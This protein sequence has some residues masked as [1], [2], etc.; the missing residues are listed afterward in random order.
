MDYKNEEKLVLRPYKSCDAKEIV[1]WCKDEVSFRKW[2]ADRWEKF[3]LTPDD[4]NDKY[5]KNNGDCE[6]EDNFYPLTFVA[7]GRIVGHMIIRY[8]DEKKETMRFGFVIVDDNIR[9]KGYGKKMLLLA[10]KYAFEML[11][12]RKITLGVFENNPQAY[13][14]YKAAGFEEIALEEDIYYEILNEKWKCIE[15]EMV[16]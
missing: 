3:G 10:K 15:M 14:C 5:F 11:G 4:M 6:Q 7:D 12:A 16:R 2:C 8:T 1:K 9:G 13:Y